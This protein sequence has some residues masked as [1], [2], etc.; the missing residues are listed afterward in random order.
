MCLAALLRACF[1]LSVAALHQNSVD[2][3]HRQTGPL[4][5]SSTFRATFANTILLCHFVIYDENI[6]FQK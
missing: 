6:A 3:N 5:T 4:I 2:E 1:K